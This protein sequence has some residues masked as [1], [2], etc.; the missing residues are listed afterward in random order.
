MAQ[1]ICERVSRGM[2]ESELTVSVRDAVNGRR[3]FLR[4]EVDFLT[5]LSG[6][7]YLPVSVLQ[8]E[9]GQGLVLIELPQESEA[10]AN[11]LW[12]RTHDLLQSN[13]TP[14]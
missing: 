2:R 7:Y 14:A 11:R 8:E 10:G 12:V 13:G 5:F 3:A 6:H 9:P 4:V 1:V